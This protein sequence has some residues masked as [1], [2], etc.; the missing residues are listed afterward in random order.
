MCTVGDRHTGGVESPDTL[1]YPGVTGPVPVRV[2]STGI[3]RCR[4]RDRDVDGVSGVM[5]GD[6]DGEPSGR[7]LSPRDVIGGPGHDRS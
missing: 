4:T 7:Y 2:S 3:H 5:E 1:V 6:I